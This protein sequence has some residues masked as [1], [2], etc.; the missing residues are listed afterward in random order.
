[1]TSALCEFLRQIVGLW[2]SFEADVRAASIKEWA[3][4]GGGQC[5]GDLV[6]R[7]VSVA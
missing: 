4:A 7:L 5:L 6:V 1:M 3:V 2:M